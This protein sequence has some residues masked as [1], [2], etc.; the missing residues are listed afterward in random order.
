M[1]PVNCSQT[2]FRF[3]VVHRLLV[4]KAWGVGLT[5]V[6]Q[7]GLVPFG[8]GSKSAG[9]PLLPPA[10]P[11]Y[12]SLWSIL[13]PRVSVRP[14]KNISLII[15]YKHQFT[16][17]HGRRLVGSWGYATKTETSREQNP[18][19]KGPPIRNRSSPLAHARCSTIP[20]RV[21]WL[22]TRRAP[23]HRSQMPSIFGSQDVYVFQI[24][25]VLLCMPTT[26]TLRRSYLPHTTIYQCA[27]FRAW[28]KVSNPGIFI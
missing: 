14:I 8:A 20:P 5:R 9:V 6:G 16:Y 15:I 21:N 24:K 17:C 10:I 22:T 27:G 12:S 13:A 3:R 2:T 18:H 19:C 25:G 23:A 11:L 4:A 26:A 1:R 7:L 28:A